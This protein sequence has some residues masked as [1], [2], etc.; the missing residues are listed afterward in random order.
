MFTTARTQIIIAG[1]I[2]LAGPG[3]FNALM[4]LGAA[5]GPNSV[6]AN[7]ANAAMFSSFALFSYLGGPLFSIF[8]NK[9]LVTFGAL[10]YCLYVIGIYLALFVSGA[11]WV[12]ILTGLFAGI[13]ASSLWTCQI[14]MIKNYSTPL[15]RACHMGIFW[16]LFN[17]GGVLGGILQFG[18]NFHNQ[19]RRASKAS[20]FTFIAIMGLSAI[21]APFLLRDP[22]KVVKADGTSVKFEIQVSSR[23]QLR[24]SLES[25]ADPAMFL[26]TIYF[27]ASTW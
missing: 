26:L 8:R 1:F 18:I 14:G 22:S 4:A 3:L 15:T 6:Y 2:A 17:F 20:Y 10:S 19:E 13:G 16:L 23:Q 25:W 7:R 9:V 24:S 11:G 12:P 21:L 5:G 27:A